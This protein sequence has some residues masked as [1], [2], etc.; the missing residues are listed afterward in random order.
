MGGEIGV[1]SN[2]G[3]GST[4]WFTALLPVGAASA[5]TELAPPAGPAGVRPPEAGRRT[6]LIA[7]DNA[8]N[9]EVIAMQLDQLG[10]RSS[11]VE[12]GRAAIEAFSA[13]RFDLILMDCQMPEVDGLEATRRIRAMEKTA[14]VPILAMTANAIEDESLYL[15]AGFD[16][17]LS[18]PVTLARL[19]AACERWTM[20]VSLV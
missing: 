20:G 1:R 4:F 14:H 9:R 15:A 2:P 16:G 8:L 6:I 11:V 7:E 13:A 3:A 12:D 18:K 10:Y 17:I 19:R 5:V